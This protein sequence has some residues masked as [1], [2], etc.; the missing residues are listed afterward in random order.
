MATKLTTMRIGRSGHNHMNLQHQSGTALGVTRSQNGLQQ[1]WV[2]LEEVR[3]VHRSVS[4]VLSQFCDKDLVKIANAESGHQSRLY[5]RC[6]CID[7]D[8]V[9]GREKRVVDQ[10]CIDTSLTNTKQSSLGFAQAYWQ[11][12]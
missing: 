7:Y 1:L 9:K 4:P 12:H 5:Q 2:Q 3:K 6:P 10:H 8:T 11:S